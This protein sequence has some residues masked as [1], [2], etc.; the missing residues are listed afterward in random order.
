LA[1]STGSQEENDISMQDAALFRV[2]T[3]KRK[4][5]KSEANYTEV[6]VENVNKRCSNCKLT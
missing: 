3:S 2:L 5:S 6:E 4:I 1:K